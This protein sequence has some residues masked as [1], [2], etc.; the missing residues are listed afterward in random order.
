MFYQSFCAFVVLLFIRWFFHFIF[1]KFFDRLS[2]IVIVWIF[3]FVCSFRLRLRKEISVSQFVKI[4]QEVFHILFV[5]KFS[6]DNFNLTFSSNFVLSS[7]F[8]SIA[9]QFDVFR[10]V[11]HRYVS[12]IS[13]ELRF[14]FDVIVFTNFRAAVIRRQIRNSRTFSVESSVY[15]SKWITVKP[16]FRIVTK[17]FYNQIAEYRQIQIYRSFLHFKFDETSSTFNN[18]IDNTSKRKSSIFSDVSRISRRHQNVD[19]T[20]II[21]QRF[22][23]DETVFTFSVSSL[24]NSETSISASNNSDIDFDV[25]DSADIR[26]TSNS[27]KSSITTEKIEKNDF[28]M[29]DQSTFSNQQRIELKKMIISVVTSV[30]RETVTSTFNDDDI[31]DIDE[32]SDDDEEK[33]DDL[34][35]VDVNF[36][37]SDNAS[38]WKSKNIDFFDSKYEN[39]IHIDD[40]IVN[41]D[42]HVFY[43]DVYAFI[44]KLKNMTSLRE[45]NKLRIVISQCLRDIVLIWHFAK[46]SNFEKNLFRNRVTLIN[47]YE[48][49]IVRFKKRASKILEKLQRFRYIMIDARNARNSRLYAQKIFRHV[50]SAELDSIFNQFIMTWN[51]LDW[52]FRQHV[53]KSDFD[54]II[55]QFF[56]KLNKRIEIWYDMTKHF[57]R[58]QSRDQFFDNNNRKLNSDNNNNKQN[59]RNDRVDDR[60]DDYYIYQS[61]FQQFRFDNFSYQ[62][63][64]Y[65]NNQ[66]SN[67]RQSQRALSFE[68]QSFQIIDENASNSRKNQKSS[69]NVERFADNNRSIDN[70][71]NARQK[72]KVYVV[73]ENDE[74][75]IIEKFAENFSHDQNAF[76]SQNFN[77]YD[78]NYEFD[79]FENDVFAI[80]FVI[81]TFAIECR[82]CHKTFEFNNQLH[83]HLRIGCQTDLR[84]IFT[85]LVMSIV[86]KTS[87]LS[88]ISV[89]LKKSKSTTDLVKTSVI[90]SDVDVFKNFDIDFGFRD[91][92]YV[93]KNVS[94]IE[95]EKKSDVCFDTN[96]NVTLI[97]ATFFHRQNFDVSIR[98]MTTF[99]TVRD[100]DTSQHQSSDY[101][102]V[103]MYF[104][105][106]KNDNFAKIFIR[107]EIHLINNFKVNMFID[108]DVTVSENVVF[109]LIKKQIFIDSCEVT[110][111]LDVRSRASHVQ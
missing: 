50:K 25:T 69:R 62:N 3:F 32:I 68:K 58:N 74:K 76:Y 8:L 4:F 42:R 15:F 57:D 2:F 97:N 35:S 63:R 38:D 87:I 104:V 10:K 1:R 111:A 48:T 23:F 88:K 73:D 39:S 11:D 81:S 108:N 52:E 46:L 51:N 16:D 44:D 9:F 34:F 106:V 47:W 79:D 86:V 60:T 55:R 5:S 20:F 103:S 70:N 90:S 28:N 40:S 77:Y 109:D 17:V 18:S 102:I 61:T 67:D 82:R 83:V 41:V 105:D 92:S 21:R 75:K 110:I 64:T 93:K 14:I 31:D 12:I 71:N 59:S 100:L 6:A 99:F 49:L 36:S 54:V 107:R 78:S 94:L 65:Q 37:Q 13:D 80:H 7:E 43:R 66:Q 72:S 24:T 95:N 98:Q 101:A 96:V 56:E 53:S 33:N 85:V 19:D 91:W 29:F 84:K 89:F 26:Q 45:K 22:R 30:I 27:Q